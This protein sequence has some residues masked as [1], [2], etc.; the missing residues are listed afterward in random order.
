MLSFKGDKAE[1]HNQLKVYCA[2]TDTTMNKT[3]IA[4]IKKH[5]QKYG[6]T[7]HLHQCY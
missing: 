6:T 4:L 1:I 2:K 3:V 5:L 7:K